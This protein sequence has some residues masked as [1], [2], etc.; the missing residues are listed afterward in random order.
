MIRLFE[1][2]LGMEKL[3]VKISSDNQKIGGNVFFIEN[4]VVNNPHVSLSLGKD[5]SPL[6]Q[7][8]LRDIASMR[9]VNEDEE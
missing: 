7:D 3:E 6:D 9:P 4:L 8:H 1:K 5:I 2:I